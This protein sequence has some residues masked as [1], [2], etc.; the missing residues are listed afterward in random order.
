MVG[1]FENSSLI[2]KKILEDPSK[3][4]DV[5][6]L[7]KWKDE[8]LDLQKNSLNVL[9]RKMM[10]WHFVSGRSPSEVPFRN[11]KKWKDEESVRP[12]FFSGRQSSWIGSP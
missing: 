10:Y 7:R 9:A 3:E 6:E 2:Y 11:V 8:N 12:R 5:L 4:Y 1:R